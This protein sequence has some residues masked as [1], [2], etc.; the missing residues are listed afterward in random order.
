MKVILQRVTEASVSVNN[1]IV[2]SIGQG[3]VVLLGFGSDDSKAKVD[4]MIKKI[5]SLRIFPNDVG[6]VN[7]SIE[8]IDGSILVV[9]Q[10]TLYADSKKGNRPNFVNAASP[11]I[12]NELYI[13]FIEKAKNYFENVEHGIFGTKMLLNIVND[14][15]FTLIIE[16]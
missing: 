8:D 15:P 7:L 10:F 3:Y 16:D 4:K 14:G 11:V 6:K 13:H 2:G 9:S 1:Y 5:H 12:A